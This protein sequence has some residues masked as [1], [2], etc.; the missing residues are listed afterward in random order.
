MSYRYPES[1]I[2]IFAR[3]PLPGKVKTRLAPALGEQ[4]AARL[5]ARLVMRTVQMAL[6]SQLAPVELCC[7]PEKNH[8]LFID[9]HRQGSDL[10]VQHGGDLGERMHRAMAESLKDSKSVILIGT[11]CPPMDA[12]YL[13][14]AIIKLRDTDVVLGPAEDGGYVLIGMRRPLASIY[15]GISWGS[16]RVLQQTRAA[17]QQTAMSWTELP[18]LWDL[19]RPEDLKR[20]LS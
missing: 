13:E 9:L 18:T 2:L 3:T 10:S 15:K 6:A 7:Q 5:H 1:R 16:N 17:L 4:G 14:K 12:V 20:F 11:D 8:P 19:D